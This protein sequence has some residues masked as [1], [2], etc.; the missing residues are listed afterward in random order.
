MANNYEF[1]GR[2]SLH[3]VPRTV[4]AYYVSVCNDRGVGKVFSEVVTIARAICALA[5]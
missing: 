4:E 1:G 3:M 5:R 2:K